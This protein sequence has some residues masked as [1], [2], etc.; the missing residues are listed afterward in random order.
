MFNLYF[1]HDCMK[2]FLNTVIVIN[3]IYYHYE[4]FKLLLAMDVIV[5]KHLFRLYR[6]AVN[7]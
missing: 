4:L 3:V 6:N 1:N 5:M 7:T 2:T